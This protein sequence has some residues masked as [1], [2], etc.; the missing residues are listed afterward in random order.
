ME[1]QLLDSLLEHFR[2]RGLLQ[3]AWQAADRLNPCAGLRP[4]FEPGGT[5]RR[6][7]ATGAEQIGRPVADLVESACAAEWY[8]Q[9]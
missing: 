7:D 8:E 6:N 9:L 3:S 5:G 2:E 1:Q 4:K